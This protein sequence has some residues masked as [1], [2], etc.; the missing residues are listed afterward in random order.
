MV[1]VQARYSLYRIE[2][3]SRHTRWST[4]PD[5]HKTTQNLL[6]ELSKCALG[7]CTGSIIVEGE[8]C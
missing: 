3:T 5:V 2:C 1:F 4:R 7:I 6:C 8:V